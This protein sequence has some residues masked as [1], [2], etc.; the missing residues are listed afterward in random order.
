MIDNQEV[1]MIYNMIDVSD[2][3]KIYW[4]SLVNYLIAVENSSRQAEGH[5]TSQFKSREHQSEGPNTHKD[6]ITQIC[7]SSRSPECI[8]TGG[9]DG[10]G[11]IV[12]IIVCSIYVY[13]CVDCSHILTTILYDLIQF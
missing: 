11:M 1:E 2:T 6:L 9:R 3:R 8:I 10:R 13:T 7:Y 12:L 4:Q 5:Y